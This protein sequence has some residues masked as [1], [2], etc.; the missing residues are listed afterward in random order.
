CFVLYTRCTNN[1]PEGV[2]VQRFS[3]YYFSVLC[4][5]FKDLFLDMPKP[6]FQGESGS[7]GKDFIQTNQTLRQLFS[8]KNESF[9]VY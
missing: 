8:G 2:T 1:A 7:K 6:L 4:N 3:Y 9:R 5:S